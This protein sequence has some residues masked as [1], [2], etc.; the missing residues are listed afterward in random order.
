MTEFEQWN[1]VPGKLNPAD[2]LTRGVTD[3]SEL[4]KTNKHGT[5]WYHGPAFLKEEQSGWPKSPIIEGIA[6]SD[7]EIKG[8]SALVDFSTIRQEM[9][10]SSRFSRW[11]KMKRTFAWILRFLHNCKTKEIVERL[12]Q[13][14]SCQEINKGEHLIIRQMQ[15]VV[16]EEEI[17]RLQGE[18][19][20]LKNHKRSSL[21]PFIDKCGL[22]R[23]GGRLKNAPIS[24]A[25]KQQII[26]PKDH[27]ITE[28]IITQEHRSNGHVGA[29][30]V[31]ANLREVWWV[32]N[33]RAAIKGSLRKCFLCHARRARRIHTWPI[34]QRGALLMESHPLPTVA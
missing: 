2:L 22:L 18:K 21:C 20:L 16:F 33:G 34:F 19:P 23:V 1:H 26:L 7:Q 11:I 10:D 5:H 28:M 4:M 25:S 29:E 30:H 6:E 8:K 3:P 9:I 27:P 24:S 12:T 13:H 15:N 14:L 17:K 32:I 31:L